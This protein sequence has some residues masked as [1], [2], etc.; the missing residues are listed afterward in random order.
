MGRDG[1]TNDTIWTA[2]EQL[3]SRDLPWG[4]IDGDEVSGEENLIW[5]SG[6]HMLMELAWGFVFGCC[7]W[8]SIDHFDGN[9]WGTC[10]KH[11]DVSISL[12]SNSKIFI[13]GVSGPC[14]TVIVRHAGLSF[15]ILKKP[16]LLI[17]G[18]KK[19]LS[20]KKKYFIECYHWKINYFIK[21][22]R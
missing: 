5:S 18:W 6:I 7:G 3:C 4:G 1:A 2:E 8:H 15:I 17:K 9:R 20:L 13:S 22:Y 16:L 19:L 14:S 10:R 12:R 11:P 21:C